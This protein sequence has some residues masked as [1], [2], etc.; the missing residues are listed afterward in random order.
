MPST[1]PAAATRRARAKYKAKVKTARAALAAA[2]LHVLRRLADEQDA[3]AAAQLSQAKVTAED[4]SVLAVVTLGTW[5]Q[6]TETG[7]SGPAIVCRIGSS[8]PITAMLEHD[9]P[10]TLGPDIAP[11]DHVRLRKISSRRYRFVAVERPAF[12]RQ[13]CDW[14]A[15]WRG[16]NAQQLRALGGVS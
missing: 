16:S 11:G 10:E 4:G 2:E 8:A 9:D 1:S 7:E 14:V 12:A 5:M 3:K 13:S 15:G 6:D